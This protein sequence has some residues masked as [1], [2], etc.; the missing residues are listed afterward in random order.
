M[1]EELLMVCLLKWR[2]RDEGI[3]NAF[4]EYSEESNIPLQK[5]RTVR[6]DGSPAI[7]GCQNGFVALCH[8]GDFFLNFMSYYFTVYQEVLCTKLHFEH[9]MK[10]IT[11]II[12]SVVASSVPYSVVQYASFK[13]YCTLHC[14]LTNIDDHQVSKNCWW[15]LL[16]FCFVILMFSV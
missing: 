13:S 1:K 15:K 3:C 8:K 14:V 7:V 6:T 12:N 5:L 2:I 9:V 11:K 10:I 16:C 4:M